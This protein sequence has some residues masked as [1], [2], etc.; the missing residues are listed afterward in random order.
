[1]SASYKYEQDH[2]EYDRLSYPLGEALLYRPFLFERYLFGFANKINEK[3]RQN[4][5]AIR[6]GLLRNE[7]KNTLIM[8]FGGIFS[9]IMAVILILLLVGYTIRGQVSV[10]IF[11]SLVTVLFS[12]SQTLSWDLSYYLFAIAKYREFFKDLTEFCHLSEVDENNDELDGKPLSFQQLEFRNVSFAYPG[13]DYNILNGVSFVMEKDKHYSF[14]GLNGAGKTTITKLLTGLYDNYKGEI[15]IDGVEL[16]RIPTNTLHR[17]FAVVFQDYAR[18]SLSIRDNIAMGRSG[19]SD[20]DVIN[21][22]QL[23]GLQETVE[24]LAEGLETKLGKIYEGGLDISGGQWQRIAMARAL[25]SAAP[26]K[27][28]DEPTAALDPISESQ[29]YKQF[30]QISANSTTIFISHRLGSTKLADVIFVLEDGKITE[31]GTH[32]ELMKKNGTYS[33]M[34]KSQQSWYVA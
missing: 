10:G 9:T 22:L 24:S 27:I 1:G 32:E 26:V 23:S 31:E 11:L 25:A 6:T 28:F 3:W 16:R 14:V 20:S 5:A 12:L 2:V 17:Y 34:Y 29:V 33:T 7:F 18:F 13:T 15:L 30:N 19:I 21:A 4:Y 8:K